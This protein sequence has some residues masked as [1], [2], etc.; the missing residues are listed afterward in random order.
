MQIQNL[1]LISVIIPTY[2]VENYII[3]SVNSIINQTYK[4]IEII[5]VDDNSNDNTFKILNSLKEL[6][7]RIKLYKNNKNLK[8]VNTLNFA[9]SV[10]SGEYIARMDG[11][12]ISYKK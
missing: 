12:D 2:N 11:D 7:S 3:D 5:I 4:N 1:P 9:I 6:D 10:S 8:I